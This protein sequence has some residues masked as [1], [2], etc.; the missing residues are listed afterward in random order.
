ML[1]GRF[2]PAEDDYTFVSSRGLSVVDYVLAPHCS[3]D[4]CHYFKVHCVSDMITKMHLFSTLSEGCKKPDHSI[5]AFAFTPSN[6]SELNQVCVCEQTNAVNMEAVTKKSETKKC[7]NFGNVK[8]G[9]MNN[10]TWYKEIDAFIFRIEN[11]IKSDSELNILYEEFCTVTQ[12]ELDKYVYFKRISN[13]G[14]RKFKYSKPYWN[15]E[16]TEKYKDMSSKELI[17]RKCKGPR[18]RKQAL[19]QEFE[20]SRQTFDKLLSKTERKYNREQ[21]NDLENFC[22]NNPTK[23]WNKIKQLS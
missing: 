3:V 2:V 19:R 18:S 22:D 9:Y 7:Y 8:E 15:S 11:N 5:L 20:I 1:N 14:S 23:F 13:T 10:E 6:F 17:Y 21:V 12:K 4:C 16:L